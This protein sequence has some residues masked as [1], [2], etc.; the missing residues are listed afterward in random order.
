MPSVLAIVSK[1]VFEKMVSKSVAIGDVVDTDKYVSSHAAFEKL[2]KGDAIFL[3]TVRPP[4]EK[5]WLVGILESPKRKKDAWASAKNKTPIRDITSAIKKLKF[6]TGT[7]I[8]AKKGALGMSLQTPRVLTDEDVALLRGRTTSAD[9]YRAEASEVPAAARARA[10]AAAV[11]DG[12]LRLTNYRRPLANLKALA[13]PQ[14]KQLQRMATNNEMGK[15]ER[16]VKDEDWNPMELVD[17]VNVATG[18]VTHQLYVWPYGSGEV[19]ENNSLTSV[20]TIIQ[21]DYQARVGDL[22][23][24]RALAAAYAKADPPLSEVVD[25]QLDW[26]PEPPTRAALDYETATKRALALFDTSELRLFDTLTPEQRAAVLDLIGAA[27]DYG[28]Q[29]MWHVGVPSH[30]AT[31]RWA[32]L[33]PPGPFEKQ[34]GKWPVWKWL[35]EAAFQRVPTSE[36]VAAIKSVLSADEVYALCLAAA[37][38]DDYS[39][40]VAAEPWK[41]GQSAGTEHAFKVLRVLGALIDAY[42]A[43]EF[44]RRAQEHLAKQPEFWL[45]AIATF[46]LVAQCHRRKESFPD[47]FM[48]LANK[49]NSFGAGLHLFC[50]PGVRDI[51]EVMTPEQ[52]VV[53][54]KEAGFGFNETTN[55]D[56]KNGRAVET[57]VLMGSW[58]YADLLPLE[59]TAETVVEAITEW[60]S[61][62][63]PKQQVLDVIQKLGPVCVPYLDKALATKEK[64]PHRGVL[65]AARKLFP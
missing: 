20:A 36:A 26:E 33:D 46:A 38:T 28:V 48:A 22:P 27:P 49:S 14:R 10:E 39:L 9:A 52:R 17:V 11:S 60:D 62:K 23:F 2:G 54:D 6:A 42:D 3:V 55:D 18:K 47:E 13:E 21:H 41:S 34:A 1:A 56:K 15:I 32:Q 40:F 12:S 63:K 5:L 16:L 58:W 45:A 37:D 4:D 53:F 64:Y 43:P 44:A 29:S 61:E 8:T 24:R 57:P 59:E 31:R 19:Y 25:F 30:P 35:T 7:G 51:V 50:G 65:A